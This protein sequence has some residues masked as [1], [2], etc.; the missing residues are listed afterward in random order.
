MTSQKVT[1]ANMPTRKSRTVFHSVARMAT[2]RGMSMIRPTPRMTRPMPQ[3]MSLRSSRVGLRIMSRCT[4]TRN[5]S[6][7][8]RKGDRA[9][10]C[11]LD[12]YAQGVSAP[13]APAAACRRGPPIPAV[14]THISPL[15]LC[16][17]SLPPRSTRRSSFSWSTKVSATTS[18]PACRRS[19]PRGMITSSPREMETSTQPGGSPSSPIVQ[20][21]A[22]HC[23][24]AVCPA[25]PW[26]IFPCAGYA[27][28]LYRPPRSSP[29]SVPR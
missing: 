4:L 10:R 29:R 23:P 25:P 7:Q 24:P 16:A 18:S 14:A 21:Q 8:G 19:S 27:G 5:I 26:L 3:P 12:D 9:H 20:A 2:A 1:Q 22:A 11:R 28:W 13:A 17:G 15:S 6:Q